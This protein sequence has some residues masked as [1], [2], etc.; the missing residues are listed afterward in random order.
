M[1]GYYLY[2]RIA[3]WIIRFF[4]EDMEKTNDR[5]GY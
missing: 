5:K 1:S 4:P 2:H 3:N